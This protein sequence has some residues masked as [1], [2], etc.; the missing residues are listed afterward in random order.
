[1]EACRVTVNIQRLSDRYTTVRSPY[2]S[3]AA[4]GKCQEIHLL[5]T[6]ITSCNREQ[7]NVVNYG[8]MFDEFEVQVEG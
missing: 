7:Q 4:F 5:H 1:M 6:N 8:A 2:P 3:S